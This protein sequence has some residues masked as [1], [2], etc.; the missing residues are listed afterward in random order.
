MARAVRAAVGPDYPLM[1]DAFMGW[2]LPFALRMLEGLEELRPA[3]M[4]EPLPP[5]HLEGFRRLKAAHPSV[6]LATG[7]HVFG[8]H[9]TLWLLQSGAIDVLQNDPDWTGGLSEQ[10]HICS[11]GS[12]Y[13][14]PVVAH[15]HSLLPALHIAAAR[16]PAIVPYVEF[17]LAYQPDKQFFQAER[18]WPESGHLALPQ[19]PGLGLEL[20]PDRIESRQPFTD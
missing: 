20:D 3:W 14:I 6:P 7:E 5:E 18:F 9:Q 19:S 12:A 17:L 10:L 2:D 11:L 4:E 15:G 8:R 13:D 1:F 16:S